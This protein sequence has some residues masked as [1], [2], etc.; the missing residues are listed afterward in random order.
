[1]KISDCPIFNDLAEYLK[2]MIGYSRW[3]S[4]VGE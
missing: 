1:M 2:E 4:V 3:F